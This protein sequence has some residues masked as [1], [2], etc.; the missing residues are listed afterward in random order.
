MDGIETLL[1]EIYHGQ[2]R[3]SRDE[4]YAQ[5]VAADLPAPELTRLDGLPEGEYSADEVVAALAEL[6]PE[7]DPQ[8]RDE[9][10][11]PPVDLSDDDLVR[12]LAQLHRT[13]H[14][15]LRHGSAQALVRHSERLGDLE[16]E[17]ISRFPL[18]EVAPDRL[19]SGARERS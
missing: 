2:E 17:Y 10:G 12:E 3:K 7:P 14:E 4:V 19:R 6:S 8:L 16:A 11:V 18:R 13:R 9:S 15:T 5:A 1:D